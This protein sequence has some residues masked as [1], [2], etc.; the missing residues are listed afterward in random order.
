MKMLNTFSI[1]FKGL[2]EGIHFFDYVLDDKF[3]GSFEYGEI[4][5]GSVNV[6]VELNK[7]SMHLELTFRLKGTV[8][9]ECDRCLEL[10]ELSIECENKLFVKF[11]EEHC[12][13]DAEVIV[14]MHSE[15]E[16]NIAQ[17]LY[18]F[19]HLSL[20]IQRIHPENEKGESTCNSEMLEILDKHKM[21]INQEDVIDPRWND[22]RDFFK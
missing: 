17:F 10:V 21:D 3:F 16:I 20:P 6:H 11:G 13:D 18:E 9:T 2:K 19:A 1:P 14:L 5:K 22:L 4:K 7:H 15:G 12:E 8:H